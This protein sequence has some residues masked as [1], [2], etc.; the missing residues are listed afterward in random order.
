MGG[1]CQGGFVVIAVRLVRKV[2]ADRYVQP[3]F[4]VNTI[5]PHLNLGAPFN[6]AEGVYSTSTWTKWI[7]EG[8]VDPQ[9]NVG[10]AFWAPTSWIIN[11]KDC[12][13]IHSAALIDPHTHHKRLWAAGTPPVGINEVLKIWRDEYPDRKGIPEHLDIQDPPKQGLKKG[14]EDALIEKYTGRTY[15]DLKETALQTLA[16][17]R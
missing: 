2:Q 3:H 12:A 16:D 11:V 7:Y 10:V 15:I 14:A 4:R 9:T 6:P 17:S 1:L 8:N 5:L 13:A